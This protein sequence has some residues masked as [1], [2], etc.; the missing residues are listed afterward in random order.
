[1]PKVIEINLNP[2]I[3]YAGRLN[4][5]EWVKQKQATIV[6]GYISTPF[7]FGQDC[8]ICIAYA[9]METH[10]KLISGKRPQYPYRKCS[11]G[12]FYD[13]ESLRQYAKETQG[14]VVGE[15]YSPNQIQALFTKNN[16]KAKVRQIERSGYISDICASIDKG[17]PAMVFA[18]IS[19]RFR[20]GEVNKNFP[21]NEHAMMI[22]GYYTENQEKYFIYMTWGEFY[23][24]KAEQLADA[25]NALEDPREPEQFIKWTFLSSMALEVSPGWDNTPT[26]VRRKGFQVRQATNIEKATLKRF[27]ITIDDDILYDNENRTLFAS[28]KNHYLSQIDSYIKFHNNRHSFSFL[29]GQD[30]VDNAQELKRRVTNF[31]RNEYQLFSEIKAYL[32]YG[33][34]NNNS[35]SLK[36]YLKAVYYPHKHKMVGMSKNNTATISK[37]RDHS[38][39]QNN[40]HLMGRYF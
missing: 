12:F 26:W 9:L 15:I 22:V 20:R 14:S 38:T 2:E 39:S 23:Y 3:Q 13:G 18:S 27:V 32:K 29:H 37:I 36:T 16:L 24:C 33:P 21:E 30:G 34:G 11:R 28:I 8:K 7:Q 35:N 25:A 5:F 40:I 4:L 10:T 17:I 19:L 31:C 6:P 1:M